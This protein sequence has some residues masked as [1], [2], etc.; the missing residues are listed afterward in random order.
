MEIQEESP[1]LSDPLADLDDDYHHAVLHLAWDRHGTT[2]ERTLLFAFVELLPAEIPPPIDDY[3]PKSPCCSHRLAHDSEHYVYVRHAVTTARRALEW[4]EA[5]RQGTAVLPANDGTIPPVEDESAKHLKLAPLGQ[6]PIWPALIG[7]SESTDTTPF[8][9]HWIEFPR[10]HHL[11]PLTDFAT[12]E[13][14]S[15]DEANTA[16]HWLRDALHFDLGEFP[17]YWGS[18]HLIAP[19]PVYREM[20]TRLQPRVP[21]RESVL[22]RFQPRM[23]K[24]VEGLELTFREEDPWGVV[25]SKRATL[26]NSLSRMNFD[27]E[28]NAVM[29]DVWDPR[30]GYLQV[31]NG[32]HPFLKSIQLNFGLAE[33]TI[34]KSETQTYEVMRS[35]KPETSVMGDEHKVMQ[36]RHRMVVAHYAREK[37][38]S[39]SAHDQRWFRR[40]KEDARDLLRSLLNEAN[41]E[42]LVIDPY[43]AAEELVNF[44]LAVG[45]YDIPIRILSSAEVLKEAAAEKSEIEKGDQLLQTLQELQQRQKMNPFEIHVMAGDRPAVHDRF[46]VIDDRIWLLG[47]S[48]NEF[49]ARGTMMLRLPD[50]DAVRGDLVNA[51]NEAEPLAA[52]VLRR[53]RRRESKEGEPT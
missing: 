7:T 4:Y 24:S 36:A 25:A 40:Q 12:G 37:R 31:S 23:G 21:P 38:R 43:F 26:R 39:A 1:L 14:W 2:N 8:V 34:V 9:P 52:W 19:N 17:E 51:W 41:R 49:G 13:L 46:L 18:I 16:R 28:V 47:S 3:D 33:R 10:A 35:G 48:L 27:R 5:C 29:E 15:M 30:R 32:A 11:L 45:R 6:E 22:L 50:P 42:V 44:A 53:R 20:A